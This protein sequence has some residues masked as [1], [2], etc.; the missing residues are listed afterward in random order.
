MLLT[1]LCFFCVIGLCFLGLGVQIFFSR[2]KKFPITE[3]GHHPEMRK[4]GIRCAREE[5]F[6]E[7]RKTHQATPSQQGAHCDTC[8]LVEAC[9]KQNC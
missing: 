8:G 5:E 4:R 9:E 1:F 3:V 2:K 7:W 6:I